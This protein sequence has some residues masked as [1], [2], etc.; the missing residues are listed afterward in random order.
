MCIMGHEN[1][2]LQPLENIIGNLFEGRRSQNHFRGDPSEA[3]DVVGD[4]SLRIDKGMKPVRDVYAIMM[5]DGHLCNTMVCC[6][7][8][9]RLNINNRVHGRNLKFDFFT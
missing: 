8:A 3:R 5:V 7:S 4:I 1:L 6:V 9:G 2:A